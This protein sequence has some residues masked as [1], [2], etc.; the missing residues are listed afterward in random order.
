MEELSSGYINSRRFEGSM[1]KWMRSIDEREEE[2]AIQREEFKKVMMEMGYPPPDTMFPNEMAMVIEYRKKGKENIRKEFDEYIDNV[3]RKQ[4]LEQMRDGWISAE[5]CKERW[6]ILADAM[7]AYFLEKYSLIIPVLIIQAE[8]IIA[9]AK[10]HTGQMSGKQLQGHIE[11]ILGDKSIKSFD[12][13]I[14]KF[15]KDTVLAKFAHGDLIDSFLSRHAILHGADVD[16]PT[17]QNA[18]KTILLFDYLFDKINNLY[19]K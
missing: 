4:D 2:E 11:E 13:A 16:Y 6:G 10:G 5:W 18:L 17:K 14:T 8:G 9:Q 7:D 3:Y 12:D 19:S 15:Y 1:G